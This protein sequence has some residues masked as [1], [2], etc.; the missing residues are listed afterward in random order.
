MS[1]NRIFALGIIGFPDNERTLLRSMCLLTTERE[2]GYL[3]VERKT[4]PSGEIILVNGDDPDAIAYLNSANDPK[5]PRDAPRLYIGGNQ[6]ETSSHKSISRPITTTHLFEALDKITVNVLDFNVSSLKPNGEH[7]TARTPSKSEP[8]SEAA[9]S[10]S[11]IGPA[12]KY[13]ALVVDNSRPAR[14]L[15][16]IKLNIVGLEVFP[17][18]TG[19]Q[20]LELLNHYNFDIIF[21]D[22]TLPSIDGYEVCK[23]IKSIKGYKTIP[24]CILSEKSST[25]DKIKGK[26]SGC[27]EY[28]TKPV[29]SHD[30]FEVVN[31]LLKDKIELKPIPNDA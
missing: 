10:N 16:K 12:H 28:L 5:Y 29:Q 1:D 30:F 13:R 14:E 20:A 27:D 6:V 18:V 22:I 23:R 25:V 21:L 19:E 15:L 4:D 8:P 11:R 17:A 26:M 7:N 24:I 3:I 9:R 31:K 2:R